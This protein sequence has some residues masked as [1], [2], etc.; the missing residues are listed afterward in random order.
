MWNCKLNNSV[1][2]V[3]I[4]NFKKHCIKNASDIPTGMINRREDFSSGHTKWN[5]RILKSDA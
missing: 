1:R 5:R 2:V 3:K 4:W